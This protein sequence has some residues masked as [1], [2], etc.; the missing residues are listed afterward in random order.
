MV[1]MNINIKS[2]NLA[3]SFLVS[4]F[5]FLF[6]YSAS[7]Q[8]SYLPLQNNAYRILDRLEI[9]SGISPQ[10][11]SS[12][13]S[14]TRGDAMQFIN[15]CNADTSLFLTER[16]KE[17]FYFMYCE[18]NDWLNPE[19]QQQTLTG[20][21][22]GY[23]E[24]LPN[25]TLYR[26]IPSSQIFSSKESLNY[27]ET[28]KPIWKYFYQTPANWFQLDKKDFY[29]RLN[30]IVNFKV[31]R[32]GNDD[33]NLFFNQRGVEVRG[34]IDDRI[35]FYSQIL[36]SQARFPDY[37][38]D[39]ISQNRAL[40]GNGFYKTYQSSV[41]DG[42]DGFDYL[43][44]QAY[45]SMNIT[46]S[47]GLQFG[48]G[49]NFIGNGYRSM[50]L[51][52]FSHNYL[53]LKLNWKVWKLHYQNL[54]TELNATSAQANP[55]ESFLPKKYMAAHYLSFNLTNN[56]SFGIYEAVVFQRRDGFELNYLNPVILYRSVEHLLDSEDNILAGVELKWNFLKKARFYS[57]FILDEYKFGELVAGDGWW[58]NKF[59]LQL[60]TQVIDAF[61]VDHLDLRVEYN[62]A[63]PYTYSHRDSLGSNYSH[64]NQ[65][66]AHPLGANFE[67]LIGII[68]Y[69]PT[70]RI[71]VEARAIRSNFGE[72]PIGENWGGNILIRNTTRIQEYNNSIG[73]GIGATTTLFGLEISYALW[74]NINLDLQYFYRKKDSELD[75]RDDIDSYI[76]GGFRMNIGKVRNDF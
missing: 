26:F 39:Y 71:F 13:K 57:Q 70:K 29:I 42:L 38:N 36:D 25:D 32:S 19:L 11:N 14:F 41:I 43:N 48:H 73:Q 53:Y 31:F 4:S 46:K 17:D 72:D 35:Y 23:F 60:G 33:A 63:R 54:F 47:I 16:D 45:I 74:H 55:G 67:E 62:M 9:K 69:K 58:G 24:K 66:L 40:P 5:L 52:D 1:L 12:L 15:S 44:G 50:I 18:N 3:L 7:S 28:E 21:K 20:K 76:G 61:G 2:N 49:R 56:L 64:Y 6:I 30:P 65:S 8:G 27:I 51:S 10:Y 68:Q 22:T 59:G 34:G 37:V 75:D